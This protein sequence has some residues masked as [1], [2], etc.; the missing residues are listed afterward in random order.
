MCDDRLNETLNQPSL[1]AY[2]FASRCVNFICSMSQ[3]VCVRVCIAQLLDCKHTLTLPDLHHTVRDRSAAISC[4]PKV[5]YQAHHEE[6]GS[7]GPHCIHC[8]QPWNRLIQL[9]SSLLS[10]AYPPSCGPPSLNKQSCKWVTQPFK[11]R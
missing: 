11:A 5:H 7:T 10:V 1:S 2:R 3:C 9:R 8:M 4:T 6:V